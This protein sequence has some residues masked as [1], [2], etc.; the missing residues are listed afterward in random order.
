MSRA[1]TPESPH[2]YEAVCAR[3]ERADARRA[4]RKIRRAELLV[5]HEGPPE[6]SYPEVGLIVGLSSTVVGDQIR[7]AKL[8]RKQAALG[9]PNPRA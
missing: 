3:V 8:E 7:R 1:R 9:K 2:S 5:I 4:A 6:R